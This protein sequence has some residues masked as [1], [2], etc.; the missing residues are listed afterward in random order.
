TGHHRR[1]ADARAGRGRDRVRPPAAAGGARE[2]AGGVPHLARDGGDPLA[3]RPRA[4]HLRGRDRGRDAAG[5]LR[6]G[7]RHQDDRRRPERGGRRMSAPEDDLTG[8]VTVAARL[9]TYLR[10]G[11]IITPLLTVLS[12]FVVGGLVVLITGHNPFTTYK[13]IFD[14]TGLNWLFPWTS[15]AD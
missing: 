12:A 9:S 15:S 13:A 6:G 4:G 11:G 5:R 1:A 14:G 3:Q 8:E 10:G 7:L 2:G